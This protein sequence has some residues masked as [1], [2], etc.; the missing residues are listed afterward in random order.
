ML[1]TMQVGGVRGRRRQDSRKFGGDCLLEGKARQPEAFRV[2]M[3]GFRSE[4]SELGD[5]HRDHCQK[6]NV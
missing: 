3:V 6:I 4:S 5:N 2:D 1:G